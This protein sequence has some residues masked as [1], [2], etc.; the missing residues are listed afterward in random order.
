[1]THPFQEG[2][3]VSAY[4]RDSGHEEQELSIPQQE[5]AVREFCAAEG[6]ILV[7]IFKDESR[8]GSSAIGREAF[9][10]MLAHFVRDKAPE[11]GL[12]L[13]SFARFAR[14]DLDAQ[15]H[16]AQLRRAG[17]EIHSLTDQVPEGLH[18]R[19]IEYVIDYSNA[20]YLENL[21]KEVKRGLRELVEQYGGIPG[22]PPRGFRREKL[23]V[24]KRRDGQ[25][26]IVH[27]WAPRSDDEWERCR[28]AWELRAK[29]ATLAEI[30]R[31]TRLY[32]SNNSYHRFFRNRIYLGV[33][34]FGPLTIPGYCEALISEETWNLVQDM[35]QR[36]TLTNNL[37]DGQAANHP[38]R[39]RGSYLL[40]GLAR[41]GLCGAAVNGNTVVRGGKREYKYYLCS[42]AKRR[43]DCAS[44]RIPGQRLEQAVVES[45]LEHVIQPASLAELQAEALALHAEQ[46]H[47]GTGEL[48][49][50]RKRSGLIKARVARVIDA[51][52]R[53]SLTGP[54][55][56][57]YRDLELER[58][59]LQAQIKA[60][61]ARQS[62]PPIQHTLDDLDALAGKLRDILQSGP[63][64]LRREILQGFVERILVQR[65]GAQ[66]RVYVDYVP[67]RIKKK[68]TK[69]GIYV[70]ESS[71]VR[72]TPWDIK[73]WRST[74][75]FGSGAGGS[76]VSLNISR[77]RYLIGVN[78][79]AARGYISIQKKFRIE[80]FS[81]TSLLRSQSFVLR[82][83]MNN[84]YHTPSWKRIREKII[85]RDAGI[86]VTCGTDKNLMVHHKKPKSDGGDDSLDNLET[87]CKSCHLKAHAEIMANNSV[88]PY[89]P[90]DKELIAM[91][92]WEK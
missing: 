85:K 44:G 26:H 9:Q 70:P 17:Y 29:G 39:R 74:S 92:I 72:G 23:E 4:L 43:K 48:D 13:W 81:K 31:R 57:K 80:A 10:D 34:E 78:L 11:A 64:A 91:G 89:N 36:N 1:M 75:R 67:P 7:R 76:R 8:P 18:G 25:P 71:P 50:L 5:K 12:L 46:E 52:S 47:A 56:E 27:R 83:P 14:N 32:K 79:Y 42:R 86:C 40:S 41:C 68:L 53:L 45:L 15:F 37:A 28:L 87:L 30:R 69:T 21:S 24:G 59:E 38:N 60:L 20:L 63:L 19:L 82:R 3:H 6:L 84:F 33:L 77:S 35:N 22:T 58:L 90:T 55:E 61:E 88:G 65:A 2:D 51:I 62:Q 73:N 66:V 49:A 54:L 16:K